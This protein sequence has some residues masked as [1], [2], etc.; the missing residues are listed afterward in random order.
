MAGLAV[1]VL[2]PVFLDGVTAGQEVRR[3]RQQVFNDPTGQELGQ[4][5][6]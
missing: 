4:P 6:T 3:V 1:D 5:P 2:A